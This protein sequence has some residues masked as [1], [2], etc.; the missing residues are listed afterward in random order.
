MQH[1]LDTGQGD[2]FYTLNHEQGSKAGQ[3][4]GK[5]KLSSQGLEARAADA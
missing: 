3:N 4:M 1:W 2:A 5:E